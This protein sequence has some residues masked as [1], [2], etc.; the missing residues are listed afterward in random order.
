MHNMYAHVQSF[1]TNEG[2]LMH[3]IDEIDSTRNNKLL[4]PTGDKRTM[5]RYESEYPGTIVVNIID[6]LHKASQKIKKSLTFK[7]CMTSSIFF[8]Q[9]NCVWFIEN[10]ISIFF[11]Q[12]PI[13][14]SLF[15]AFQL[16]SLT[17]YKRTIILGKCFT[18]NIN[19]QIL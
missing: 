15:F 7:G 5:H 14:F 2:D 8:A 13:L 1:R 16:P 9:E 11:V 4:S 3:K 6:K 10:L 12:E 17:K 18:Q 19:I